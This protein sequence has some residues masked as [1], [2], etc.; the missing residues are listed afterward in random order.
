VLRFE[1]SSAAFPSHEDRSDTRS[2]RRWQSRCA[3]HR[4]RRGAVSPLYCRSAGLSRRSSNPRCSLPAR[5]AVRVRL[6]RRPRPAPGPELAAGSDVHTC[7]SRLPMH[8]HA[9]A[10]V[11][12]QYRGRL[13]SRDSDHLALARG[14]VNAPKLL[15]HQV[16]AI[17]VGLPSTFGGTC[18]IYGQNNYLSTIS[19]F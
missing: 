16:S 14:R 3:R 19:T 11:T 2:E 4:G 12:N 1:E 15:E 9:H 6:T 18:E 7:R 17:R 5:L 10:R 8:T 13:L